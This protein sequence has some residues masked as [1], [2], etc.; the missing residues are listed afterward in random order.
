MII[1]GS[2]DMSITVTELEKLLLKFSSNDPA[3]Y[4]KK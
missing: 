2:L 1:N 3:I 4:Y